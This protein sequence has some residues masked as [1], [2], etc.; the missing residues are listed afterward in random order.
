MA[1]LVASE[2]HSESLIFG[3]CE[4]QLA[5]SESPFEIFDFGGV[6]GPASWV[7]IPFEIVDFW[8][9]LR[10]FEPSFGP[11]ARC[12]R[13]TRRKWGADCRRLAL[14]FGPKPAQNQAEYRHRV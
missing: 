9:G 7:G 6:W 4:A 1:Q 14:G 2:S 12:E 10:Y 5:G 3:G 8:G 13:S 11:E